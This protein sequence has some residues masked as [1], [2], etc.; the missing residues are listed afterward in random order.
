MTGLYVVD[1]NVIVSALITAEP[2]SPPNIILREML[3]GDLRFLMSVDLLAEYR[4]V[5]LRPK[6]ARYHGLS[7]DEVDTLLAELAANGTAREL[8]ETPSSPDPGDAHLLALLACD[9]RAVLVT[10]DQALMRKLTP[11]YRAITPREC[12]AA[13]ELDH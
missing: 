8:G 7:V 2:E 4:G 6:I 1:T 5:M 9:S 10:G 13:L 12:I 3:A 11:G